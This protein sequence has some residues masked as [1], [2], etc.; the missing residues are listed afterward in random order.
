MLGMS[1]TLAQKLDQSLKLSHSQ[2]LSLR[3]DLLE[4]LRGLRLYPRTQWPLCEGR[5]TFEQLLKGFRNDPQDTT[6]KCP[7]C[8][9]RF[10]PMQ[11][12]HFSTAP[13]GSSQAFM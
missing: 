9:K 10:Q 4:Q 6:S 5:L 8:K 2:T 13:N 11:V 1:L 7:H 12:R 3:L